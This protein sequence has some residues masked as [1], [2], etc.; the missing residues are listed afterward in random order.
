MPDSGI[1]DQAAA[2]MPD[3]DAGE[4]SSATAPSNDAADPVVAR[5]PDPH[6]R[7][8]LRAATPDDLDAIMALEHASFPT[9]AWSERMMR[10]ELASPHG[11]Y[12]VVDHAGEL[13][14]YAGLRAVSGSR[15]GD[16]QTI[17]VAEASRGRGWGRMLVTALMDEAARRGV[18]DLFLEVRAD[19]SVAQALY[20]SEGFREVGRRP[21]YYQPDDVDAIVMQADLR[22]RAEAARFVATVGS[23]GSA[24]S[25]SPAVPPDLASSAASAGPAA[26]A[27]PDDAQGSE[28]PA[29]LGRSGQ[30]DPHMARSSEACEVRDATDPGNL[31]RSGQ[32]DP[33]MA[34]S[35]EVCGVRDATDRAP[36]PAGAQTEVTGDA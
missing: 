27:A 28:D 12:F 32:K 36:R 3:S 21:R 25:A 9:D 18:R 22:A 1:D 10:D 33:N 14:G 30:N 24:A 35:S 13:V 26:S 19:N 17:A 8:R 11:H 15:D 5:M 31:G 2:R 34:R 20:T 16:I 7:A 23:A 6:E 29:N 4:A